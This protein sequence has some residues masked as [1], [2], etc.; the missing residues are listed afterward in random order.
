[1]KKLSAST[2]RNKK[3]REYAKSIPLEYRLEIRDSIRKPNKD[4]S[5]T[6]E[7]NRKEHRRVRGKFH[8]LLRVEQIKTRPENIPRLKIRL[9]EYIKKACPNYKK[10]LIK[11]P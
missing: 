2:R 5:R 10:R 7:A 1:M 4:W 3:S 11:R 8:H 6:S 9:I